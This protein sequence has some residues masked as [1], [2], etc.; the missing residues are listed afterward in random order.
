[1]TM[2]GDPVEYRFQYG[3]SVSYN[4]ATTWAGDKVTGENFQKTITGLNGAT[5]YYYRAQ[6]RNEAGTVSCSGKQFKTAS[7]GAAWIL[8][9][10]SSGDWSDGSLAYDY[11]VSTYAR[12]YHNINDPQWSSYIY[13]NYSPIYYDKLRFYALGNIEVS[14]VDIDIYKNGNWEDLYQGSFADRSWVEY[15]F[16]EGMVEQVRVRFYATNA[17]H[18]FFWQLYETRLWKTESSEDL[19]VTADSCIDISSEL[20]S[21]L[22]MPVD[23]KYGSAERTYYAIKRENNDRKITVVSC[24]AELNQQIEIVK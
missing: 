23:P 21:Y 1:M 13:F 11:N 2:G 22:F 4:R 8:P 20:S 24:G 9:I 5:T 7:E 15:S 3:E 19:Y 10:S 6:L 16:T 12:K 18:G 14:S 17:S